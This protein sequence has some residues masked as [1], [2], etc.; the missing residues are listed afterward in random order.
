MIIETNLETAKAMRPKSYKAQLNT[1]LKALKKK[2]DG[3]YEKIKVVSASSKEF[4]EL[5]DEINSIS[6]D[7]RA[8]KDRLEYLDHYPAVMPSHNLNRS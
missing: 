3:L 7:I 5:I 1:E 4:D 2:R 8:K 6:Q